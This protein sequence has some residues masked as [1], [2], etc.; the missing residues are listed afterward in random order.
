MSKPGAA[1]VERE[2]RARRDHAGAVAR[3]VALDQR[4]D[5]AILIDRRHVDGFPPVRV[6]LLPDL[7]GQHLARR[8]LHID[9][10]G[11]RFGEVL[12]EHLRDRNGAEARVADVMRHVG[13]REFLRFDHDVQGGGGVVA[14]ILERK[15]LHDVEHG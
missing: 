10:P 2:A 9:E 12:R 15:V 1:I 13:V 7:G 5:V 4:N 8:L 6:E 11:A 3:V 14:V